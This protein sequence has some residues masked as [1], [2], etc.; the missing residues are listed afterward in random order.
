MAFGRTGPRLED[1]CD[2]R[3][4]RS[5][6][7]ACRPVTCLRE[8][9]AWAQLLTQF[10]AAADTTPLLLHQRLQFLWQLTQ[11]GGLHRATATAAAD[12]RRLLPSH[13]A[14]QFHHPRTF[15]E[16]LVEIPIL[17][18]QFAMTVHLVGVDEHQAP[19]SVKENPAAVAEKAGK[20]EQCS[21]DLP[22]RDRATIRVEEL[23]SMLEAA[24][25]K[26]RR[27]MCQL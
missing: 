11:H 20:K 10:Q 4:S 9:T 24:L 16:A 21:E 27:M 18:P 8:L 1:C 26:A 5:N 2:T 17:A 15:R 3:S 6:A 13:Q 7:D 22:G 14:Q 25:V 19:S 12:D 23:H